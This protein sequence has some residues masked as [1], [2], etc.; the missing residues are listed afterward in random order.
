MSIRSYSHWV[1]FSALLW[2]SGVAGHEPGFRVDGLSPAGGRTSITETWNTLRF[3][4]TNFNP[5][6]KDV[7]IIVFYPQAPDVQFGREVRVP[8]ESRL[9]TDLPVGPAPAHR[10]VLGREI[11]FVL[12]E[13]DG[14]G[15]RPLP[16]LA[17]ERLRSRR[18]P[19]R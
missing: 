7:R 6:P 18:V 17:D 15:W 1:A 19:Y 11:Q 8:A 9:T 14:D 12:Y 2:P 13:R 5:D 4:I 16:A 3:T 10:S